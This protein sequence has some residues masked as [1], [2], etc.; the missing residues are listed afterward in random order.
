MKKSKEHYFNYRLTKN[1]LNSSY[2][3]SDINKKK[4]QNKLI[5]NI[6]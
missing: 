2:Y 4:K 3:N 6:T 5:R 1:N